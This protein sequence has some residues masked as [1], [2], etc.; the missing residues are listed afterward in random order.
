MMMSMKESMK[1]SM[2]KSNCWYRVPFVWLLIVIP[3]TAVIV[4]FVGLAL[5]IR[6]DDG[7]V[8]DDYYRQGKEIN[9]VL[10]RDR[11][12]A[13]KGL[14]SQVQLDDTHHELR[15]Q[16][17]AHAAADLPENIEIKFLHATRAGLDRGLVIARRADGSYQA[18]LPELA[19]GH[20]NVQLAAQDWRLVGSLFVPGDRHLILRPATP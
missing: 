2:T 19:L 1:K 6:S 7:M 8:E 15:V 17:T 10:A 16:L 12:A 4:G 11:A 9:R 18:P 5:A 13:G 3:L 14:E 20:W